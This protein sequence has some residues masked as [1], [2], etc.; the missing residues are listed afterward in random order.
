MQEGEKVNVLCNYSNKWILIHTEHVHCCYEAK[1]PHM[2]VLFT[3]RER[4]NITPVF[5]KRS[6]L[7]QLMFDVSVLRAIGSFSYLIK[8]RMLANR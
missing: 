8:H 1:R 6:F 2:C 4:V 7:Q 5:P 3:A